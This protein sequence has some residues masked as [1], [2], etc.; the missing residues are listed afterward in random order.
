MLDNHVSTLPGCEASGEV[1]GRVGCGRHINIQGPLAQSTAAEV[2]WT[3]PLGSPGWV[4][5]LSGFGNFF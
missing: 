3:E 1:R 2:K 4:K 5:D